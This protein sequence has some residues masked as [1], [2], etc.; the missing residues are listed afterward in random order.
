MNARRSIQPIADLRDDPLELDALADRLEA[1]TNRRLILDRFDELFRSGSAPDPVPDTFLPGRLLAT[2]TWPWL[3]AL[4]KRLARLWMPWQGKS[5]SAGSSTGLNRFTPSAR[6]PFK[7]LFP[8]YVPTLIEP[9]RIDAFP[10]RTRV[11]PGALDPGVD[12]LKIDYDFEANPDFIIRRILDELVQL[13]PGRYL[14]KVLF[15]VGGR[16]R[17]IGFFALRAPTGSP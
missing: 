5:F 4:G 12:V 14:G 15:R 3:D 16:F 8:S 2:S 7:V 11:E 6:I 1:R 13:A 10:F 9:D 17:P